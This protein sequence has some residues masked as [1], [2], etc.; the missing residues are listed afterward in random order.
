MSEEP[1]GGDGAERVI[2]RWTRGRNLAYRQCADRAIT[3]GMADY[4]LVLDGLA[5]FV[6]DIAPTSGRRSMRRFPTE[7][8]A[9]AWIAERELDGTAP[10]SGVRSRDRG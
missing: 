7:A 4:R 6:V 10:P 2:G 3:R 9:L 1:A 5:V 8:A